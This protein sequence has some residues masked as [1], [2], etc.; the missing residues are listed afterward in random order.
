[1]NNVSDSRKKGEAKIKMKYQLWIHTGRGLGPSLVSSWLG[2]LRE[3]LI[4]ESSSFVS[5]TA[6]RT[7]W[8]K[9]ENEIAEGGYI[10]NIHAKAIVTFIKK[11]EID[12]IRFIATFN[13]TP[14][15]QNLSYFLFFPTHLLRTLSGK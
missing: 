5:K 11:H 8:W 15:T 6:K 14:W 10:A 12:A 3:V 9:R 13:L 7:I 4:S 2:N 1:M